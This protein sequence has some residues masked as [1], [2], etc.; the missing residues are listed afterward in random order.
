MIID[1]KLLDTS[2]ADVQRNKA[3]VAGDTIKGTPPTRHDLH[4]QALDC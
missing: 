4:K 3:A 1:V 2:N